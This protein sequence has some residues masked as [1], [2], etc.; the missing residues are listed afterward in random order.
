MQARRNANLLCSPVGGQYGEVGAD[1]GLHPLIHFFASETSAQDVEKKKAE[2]VNP[3]FSLKIESFGL[4]ASRMNLD[5]KW[6]SS[7]QS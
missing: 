4:Q 2:P 5:R 7:E 3:Q 6:P 1:C